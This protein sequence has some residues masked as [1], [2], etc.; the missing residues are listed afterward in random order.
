MATCFGRFVNLGFPVVRFGNNWSR[1]VDFSCKSIIGTTD[2]VEVNEK[3]REG[4]DGR[5]NGK[6]V[7]PV[8]PEVR[9]KEVRDE[10]ELE[11]L[12]DDGFGEN[13]VKDFLSLSKD[14]MMNED[15]GP[16]RWF[17]PVDCGRPIKGSPVL[18]FLPGIDGLGMG[19]CL[20][21]KTL[22][23]VFEVRCLHIPVHD[24]TPFGDLVVFVENTVRLEHVVYPDKP[25][26]LVG[27]SFGGCLA[28]A[29]AARN[30]S[31]DLVLILINPATSIGKSQLQPL[32]PILEVLPDELNVAVPYLLSFLS[33]DPI[34]MAMVAIDKGLSLV[35]RLEQL[36]DRIRAL[37]PCLSILL[38]ILPKETLLWKLKLLKSGAAYANSRLHAVKAEV[39]VLS[40]GK[41]NILPSND[42]AQRLSNLIPNCVVRYFDDSGHTLL[43]EEGMHLL[44][45]IKSTLKYRHSKRHDYISDYIPPSVAEHKLF[46]Q[47]F[48][49]RHLTSPVMLSTLDD[50]KIV[51]GLS[52]VPNQGPIL[53]V[54]YHMLMGLELIS[55]VDAFLREKKVMVRGMGHPSLFTL[56][57]KH[58]LNDC[59]VDHVREFGAIPVTPSNLYRLLS[60][61]AF[62]LL[63]PG[64]A[65]EA[66]HRRGEEYQLFWPEQPEFVRMAARFEATIV[67]FGVVGEDDV[68]QMVMDYD[69][70]MKIPILREVIEKFNQDTIRLRADFSGEVGNQD[71][72]IPALLPKVPGRF[73]Y[74]FG[75]PIKTKGMK[76]VL[77]NEKSVNE[78]YLHIQSDIEKSLSYLKEKRE[79]DPYRGLF[80]RS[81]YQAMSWSNMD[82]VP[83][84]EL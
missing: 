1:N 14:M 47:K 33:G 58:L 74:L 73:Y 82:N 77:K 72:C 19:L 11:V 3:I 51:R 80:Q 83:F 52:G 44:G 62:I 61:N 42:E 23:R 68:F 40:S 67:P 69:D 27:D 37:L 34:R 5:D 57:R 8:V 29:V 78:L 30:P 59:Y 66:L 4:I 56:D 17:C 54:G 32:L 21:H 75:K 6:A 39:L 84:F 46:D 48:L 9:K 65:R 24:R 63:Y 53:F 35:E 15:G 22:G 76:E 81:V 28:L 60:S 79:K 71:I 31:I 45:V 10:E 43:L 16:P 2:F 49:I 26:Y 70:Q 36:S 50:G 20:H 38:D 55:L 18:L 64:G 12:W 13:T 7:V 25:I 41:D